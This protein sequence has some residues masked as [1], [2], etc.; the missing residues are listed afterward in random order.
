MSAPE[1][2]KKRRHNVGK[3]CENCRRRRVKC[4]GLQP[5]CGTCRVYKDE[6]CWDAREDLRKPI[7]RQQVEALQIRVADL[8]KMLREHGLDPGHSVGASGTVAEADGVDPTAS[9]SSVVNGIN[10]T[11]IGSQSDLD[12]R[13]GLNCSDGDP[14]KWPENGSQNHLVE[15]ETGDFQVYGPTSAFR[16]LSLSNNPGTLTSPTAE[17]ESHGPGFRKYLP[18]EVR[19]TEEEHEVAL[20]RFFRYYA[21]WGMFMSSKPMVASVKPPS[22]NQ[23]NARI[24]FYSVKICFLRYTVLRQHRERRIIRQCYT[25]PSSPSHSAIQTRPTFS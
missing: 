25:T 1:P 4:D 14:A 2:G 7:S 22:S 17:P 16:H 10:S 6:C 13:V 19:L 20:D 18:M 5:E 21:S 8:E 9:S 24:L 11:I 12:Q 15:D 3:A 23:D